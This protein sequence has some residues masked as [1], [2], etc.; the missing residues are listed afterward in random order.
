VIV[1]ALRRAEGADRGVVRWER[2]L[3]HAPFVERETIDILRADA[4][5]NEARNDGGVAALDVVGGRTRDVELIVEIGPVRVQAVDVDAI[6]IGAN[7]V[8]AAA[9]VGAAE[10]GRDRSDEKNSECAVDSHR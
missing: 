4:N 6:E 8:I 9:V 7:L 5:F 2:T 3:S 1:I 10:R